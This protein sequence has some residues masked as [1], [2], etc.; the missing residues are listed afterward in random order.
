MLASDRSEVS[1]EM[2]ILGS[3]VDTRHTVVSNNAGLL[4]NVVSSNDGVGR[5]CKQKADRQADGW[6]RRRRDSDTGKQRYA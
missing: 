1:A 6:R 4:Q 5:A 2:G 3:S